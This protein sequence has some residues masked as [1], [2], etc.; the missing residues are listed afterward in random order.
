VQRVGAASPLPDTETM[1]A[2]CSLTAAPAKVIKDA[3][4][5]AGD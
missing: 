5:K 4:I 3:G 1:T 2:L